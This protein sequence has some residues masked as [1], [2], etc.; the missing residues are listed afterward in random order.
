MVFGNGFVASPLR[1]LYLGPNIGDSG[2]HFRLGYI[3][4]N[5]ATI[6][7][8]VVVQGNTANI[9]QWYRAGTPGLCT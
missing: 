9:T 2:K 7:A 4:L 8:N 5:I 1:G 6:G 3:A